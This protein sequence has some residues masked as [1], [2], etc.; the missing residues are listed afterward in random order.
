MKVREPTKDFNDEK[1]L[2]NLVTVGDQT[3]NLGLIFR[4]FILLNIFS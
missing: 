2:E 1:L 3:D 4:S